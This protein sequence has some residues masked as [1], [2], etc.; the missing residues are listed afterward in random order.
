MR[1]GSPRSRLCLQQNYCK[2]QA[3]KSHVSY[4]LLKS[5]AV[6]LSAFTQCQ[7]LRVFPILAQPRSCTAPAEVSKTGRAEP[8]RGQSRT[9]QGARGCSHA[10]PAGL[11]AAS[12]QTHPSQQQSRKSQSH[13][14]TAKIVARIMEDCATEQKGFQSI[15]LFGLSRNDRGLV[16]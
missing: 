12:F 11:S 3:F 10:L 4:T 13:T 6:C 7:T 8:S 15:Y 16:A 9:L 1:R 2:G 5:S 14:P